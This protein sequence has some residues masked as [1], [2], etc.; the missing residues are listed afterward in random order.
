MSQAVITKTPTPTWQQSSVQQY[1]SQM[2]WQKPVPQP[3]Q[4]APVS[5]PLLVPPVPIV[6]VTPGE[7]LGLALPVGQFFARFNW[8]G[9]QAAV[10]AAPLP[11]LELPGRASSA[12]LPV[13]T[14]PVAER[15]SNRPAPEA[16]LDLDLLENVFLPDGKS[17]E[18]VSLGDFSDFF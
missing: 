2:N 13:V 9:Q 16:L 8:Q 7:P 17:G 5:N 10:S 1:F 12:A 15:P 11:E 6:T 14:K 3:T 18:G 4:S